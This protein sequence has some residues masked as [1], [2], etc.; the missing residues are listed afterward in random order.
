MTLGPP[1]GTCATLFVESSVADPPQLSPET[2]P[3]AESMVVVPA[4]LQ[5]Q[6][7]DVLKFAAHGVA[8]TLIEGGN[9]IGVQLSDP[10]SDPPS[11]ASPPS[12]LASPP[13]PPSPA[14]PL[15]ALAS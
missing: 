8:S 10:P 7:G 4:A 2:V 6:T 13:V 5:F 3:A 11:L 14:L 9:V 1:D 15:S 12:P